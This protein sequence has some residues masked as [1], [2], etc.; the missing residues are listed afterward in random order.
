[1]II[2]DFAGALVK[3]I[4]T[5]GVL[6]IVYAAASAAAVS[7]CSCTG[8]GRANP[9]NDPLESINRASFATNQMLDRHILKPV[10]ELYNMDLPGPARQG[11]HN[12][13]VNLD[14]PATF[15][16][17]VL[18]CEFIRTAQTVGRFTINSTAGVGGLVNVAGKMGIPEHKADFGET[19]AVYGV[20]G[21]PYLVL[22]LLGP[23]NLRDA[24]GKVADAML[25]PFTYIS[26]GGS[27]Y[28]LLG[29]D[30]LQVVDARARNAQT[31]D[32]LESSS[33]DFYATVRSAYSQ[34]RNAQ[35]N[36]GEEKFADL[37]DF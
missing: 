14:L 19:L 23:S 27:T 21:G 24:T 4:R 3:A 6:M 17:D 20:D 2:A 12:L 26:F 8:D 5:P 16:N 32:D 35:I 7:L 31:I 10:A 11:M 25:D 18:Q 33:L 15:G 13:L 29:R 36:R 22:P 34:H 9:T 28:F 37:P 30:T 1:M